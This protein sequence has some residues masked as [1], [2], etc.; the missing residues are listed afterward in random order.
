MLKKLELDEN[1]YP[2]LIQQCKD[3][4]VVFLSTPFD[5]ESADLLDRL[6]IP[7]FKTPSGEITN[8]RYLKHI[9]LKGKPMIV[10]TGMSYLGEVEAAVRTIQSAGNEN[11]ILLHAVSNYPA[12]PTSINLRAMKTMS[13]AFGVPVGYSDH[14]VGMEIPLAAAALGACVIEKHFTLDRN[15]PGPDHKSSMEPGELKQLVEGIRMVQAALGSGRKEPAASESNTALAARK[16]LVSAC[17]I[18]AGTVIRE[19]LICVKRPGTGLPPAFL[20]QVIGSKAR[21]DIPADSLL[22]L[23]MLT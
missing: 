12:A 15:L 8:L 16:S 2:A 14:T 4:K 9:A 11:L 3:K 10:S 21:V 17:F 19:E 5:E 6:G 13:E 20:E 22:T 1:A 7:A 23:D 18:A